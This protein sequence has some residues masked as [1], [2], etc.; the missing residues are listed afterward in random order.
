MPYV[1]VHMELSV[2]RLRPK[3][4]PIRDLCTGRC[5]SKDINSDKTGLDPILLA[6]LN[7]RVLDIID[8]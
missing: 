4:N 8:L 3:I 7:L 6:V 5:N 1:K 2:D